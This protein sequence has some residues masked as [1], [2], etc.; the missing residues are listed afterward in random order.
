MRPDLD[1]D[2]LMDDPDFQ[3]DCDFDSDCQ[4]G[5]KCYN[6]ESPST[7]VPGC[8]TTG[9]VQSHKYFNHD[10]CYDQSC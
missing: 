1:L 3:L 9:Y 7:I 4:S 6:R 5:L 8:A 10:Y 2:L